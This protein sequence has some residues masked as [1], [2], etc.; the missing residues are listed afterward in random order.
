LHTNGAGTATLAGSAVTLTGLAT[1]TGALVV[2]T[3][4]ALRLPALDK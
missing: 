3:P 2:N 1:N 4:T